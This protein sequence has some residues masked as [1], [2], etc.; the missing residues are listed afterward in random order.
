MAETYRLTGDDTFVLWDRVI[1][2]LADGSVVQITADNNIAQSVVGKNG[3]IIIAKDEQGKKCTV[4]LRVLKGS[5]DDQ[6][7]M[8][9]Y[10]TYEIDS[11]LFIVG[12]DSAIVEIDG[13]TSLFS[14]LDTAWAVTLSFIAKSFCVIPF[15]VLNSLILFPKSIFLVSFVF[16]QL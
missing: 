2:D 15:F 14:H 10:K 16:L 3:N 13:S 5:P 8:Q 6:F 4:E 12:I 1:S 11:A 7:I 9:Y